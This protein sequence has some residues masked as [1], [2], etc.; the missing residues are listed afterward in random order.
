MPTVD[1]IISDPMPKLFTHHCLE[2]QAYKG[3]KVFHSFSHSELKFLFEAY[4]LKYNKNSKEGQSNYSLI[5]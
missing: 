1:A 5:D 2:I 3:P 4:G